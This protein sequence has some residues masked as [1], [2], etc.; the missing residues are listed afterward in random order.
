MDQSLTRKKI[1]REWKKH[2]FA[3][4]SSHPSLKALCVCSGFLGPDEECDFEELVFAVPE[5]WLIDTCVKEFDELKAPDDVQSWL[6]NLYTSDE[7]HIIYELAMEENQIVM[8]T[9]I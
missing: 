9:F 7:A 1:E 2:C 8:L 5:N 4:F 3:D 6:E